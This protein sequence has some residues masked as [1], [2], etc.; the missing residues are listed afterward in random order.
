MVPSRLDEQW[1]RFRNAFA[2]VPKPAQAKGCECPSCLSDEEIHALLDSDPS[3]IVE[4]DN[5]QVYVENVLGT[6]GTKE[7]F[8]YL[9]PLLARVWAERLDDPRDAYPDYFWQALIR[10]EFFATYL[11]DPL[12]AAASEFLKAALLDRLGQEG[13]LRQIKGV[14]GIHSWLRDLSGYASVA[15]DYHLLWTGWWDMPSA[16]HAVAAVEFASLLAFEDENN[17]V[18]HKW[19]PLGGGGP[20]DLRMCGGPWSTYWRLN[21]LTFLRES[22]TPDFMKISTC[23]ACERLQGQEGENLARAVY[24]AV[25]SDRAG[26]RERI[27]HL[28]ED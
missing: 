10:Q 4:S 27:E 20:P 3:K 23:R 13:P 9:L 28:F 16:G 7:E 12:K 22:L 8:A 1:D 18:F 17:P 2:R 15:D 24:E 26:V 11:S 19:T 6:I 21:N 14:A 5:I 25:L